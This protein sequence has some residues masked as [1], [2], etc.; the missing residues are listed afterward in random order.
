VSK[1]PCNGILSRPLITNRS[2]IVSVLPQ[3]ISIKTIK[4][5][6]YSQSV[7]R[8]ISVLRHLSHPGIAR[9]VSSFRFR[10][11]AYLVLEYAEGGDLHTLVT[12]NGR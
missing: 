5:N 1:S 4:E 9:L 6:G 10:D 11:G 3:V 2:A 8:E 7:N 12:N